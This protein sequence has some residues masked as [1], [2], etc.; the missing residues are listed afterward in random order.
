MGGSCLLPFRRGSEDTDCGE[1]SVRMGDLVAVSLGSAYET[2]VQAGY[3]NVRFYESNPS[4]PNSIFKLSSY[5]SARL[6]NL[7]L[8]GRRWY[9]R[10]IAWS[11]L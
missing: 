10:V 6:P 9:S 2:Y 7:F 8:A 4:P 1:S 3:S 11:H 5:A